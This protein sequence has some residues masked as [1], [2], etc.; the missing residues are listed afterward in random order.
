MTASF[1]ESITPAYE[2][3]SFAV[4]S[5]STAI[6]NEACDLTNTLRP[7]WTEV[8]NSVSEMGVEGMEN[9]LRQAQRILRDDGATY[10]LNGDPL[11]PNVWSLDIIP[12]LLA[13]A[14]W[15]S[16]ERGLAQRSRL[17][18]LMLKDL[19]GE[20]RLLKEGV[21]PSE[22]VFSHPG[23]LRQC[24]GIRLPGAHNLI[25]HAVDLVRGGN[26]QFVA[27]GDRTQAPSGTGYVL[28]NRIAVS[29]VLP[30]LFRNSHVRRLSGFFHALRH[31][32][33]SLASHKTDTPRIVVLTPGA[34]S[35]TYFE[36]AYLANYLGFQL[37]QGA[38]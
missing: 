21:I 26:G 24:H 17:F 30:S 9:R 31:T 8:M 10:N 11:S 36:H 34:Y 16:V 19:Y 37:V 18:D 12:N 4:D 23:F 7:H 33:A 1:S 28:E 14:E 15:S 25:F 38:T 32:L 5:A 20:Q 6:Y 2:P 13:E 3:A 35:S 22:I 27:I 29:R